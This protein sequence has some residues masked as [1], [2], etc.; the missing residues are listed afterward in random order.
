MI[1]KVISE[2]D[3]KYWI[4][5]TEQFLEITK[6]TGLK[7]KDN[8]DINIITNK[9]ESAKKKDK[10]N[11]WYFNIKFSIEVK[12]SSG[13]EPCNV[14]IIKNRG[15]YEDKCISCIIYSTKTDIVNDKNIDY[16]I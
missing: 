12:S 10:E 9:L 7:I 13:V 2:E 14:R 11:S 5:T 4:P 1:V 6:A 16:N 3:N 15:K 8:Q